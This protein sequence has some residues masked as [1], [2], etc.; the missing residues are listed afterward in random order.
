L[1]LDYGQVGKQKDKLSGIVSQSPLIQLVH[2]P[3]KIVLFLGGLLAKVLPNL[4]VYNPLPVAP[5]RATS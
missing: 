4:T 3:N 5:L 2:P 1:A